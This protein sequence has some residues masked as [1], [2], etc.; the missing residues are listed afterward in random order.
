M[1]SVLIKSPPCV[2]SVLAALLF[3]VRS[4]R[5]PASAIELSSLHM[6][7][8]HEDMANETDEAHEKEG[9]PKTWEIKK[10][11]ALNKLFNGDAKLMGGG[12]CCCCFGDQTS[13]GGCQSLKRVHV[14]WESRTEVK[15]IAEQNR[16]WYTGYKQEDHVEV[17]IPV[18]VPHDVL[19][20]YVLNCYP[21]KYKG[22]TLKELGRV[23]VARFSSQDY[24]NMNF[25]TDS[26]G[27]IIYSLGQSF[28]TGC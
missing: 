6:Q 24:K 12:N 9:P 18:C 1:V 11:K 28:S 26:A 7:S 2:V 13:A 14:T 19:K 27:K 16:T 23:A 8:Y 25:K 15:K 20:K 5:P 3:Y 4:S 21:R 10:E 17:Q 22:K